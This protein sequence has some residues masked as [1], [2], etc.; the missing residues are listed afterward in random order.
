MPGTGGFALSSH[1]TARKTQNEI[2]WTM[3][4]KYTAYLGGDR[5]ILPIPRNFGRS[6]PYHLFSPASHEP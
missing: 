1:V 3:V 6:I 4:R 5:S 2:V